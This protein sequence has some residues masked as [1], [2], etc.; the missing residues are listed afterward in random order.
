MKLILCPACGNEC[1]PLA[2]T[3]PKCS[4]QFEQSTSV[5]S[6]HAEP[7]K[8]RF[9]LRGLAKW[10][11]VVP[12]IL[13]FALVGVYGFN[14]FTLQNAMNEVLKT[15][16]RNKGVEVSVHYQTYVNPSVLIYD[17][18][19]LS[20][21]NSKVDVFRSFLQFAEKM[22]NKKFNKVELAFRGETK[23]VLNGAYFQELG[24]EY[25]TQNPV[26]T[27]NHFPENLFL[28][29]GTRAYGTWTG[30]LLGVSGKQ[31][32]DFNDCHDKWYMRDLISQK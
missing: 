31:I 10:W 22:K 19:G 21:T 2:L 3:C 6:S 29:D 9:T 24:L 27:M 1:S 12:L 17:L 30:G 5:G 32:E 28:P 20:G 11:L 8:N 16:P 14:Y 26:W 4:H 15:D 13:V 18:R 7:K 25:G 23:F